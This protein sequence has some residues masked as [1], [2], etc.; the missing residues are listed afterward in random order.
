VT[1]G[2]TLT[3]ADSEIEAI[4]G[5]RTPSRQLQTLHQ[6]GFVRAYRDR[7]GRV[8]VEREHYHAVCR[9]QFAQVGQLTRPSVNVSFL[10][11]AVG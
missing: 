11:R 7:G 3:L 10:K 1:P 4:T 5:Y 6:R 2:A 9:G 8:V